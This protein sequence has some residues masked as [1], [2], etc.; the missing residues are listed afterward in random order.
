MASNWENDPIE[1]YCIPREAT[2]STV[3]NILV[4]GFEYFNLI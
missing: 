3:L 2:V 1:D 4:Y